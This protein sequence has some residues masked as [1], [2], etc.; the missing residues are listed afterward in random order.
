MIRR[1]MILWII[2]FRFGMDCIVLDWGYVWFS[3]VIMFSL[4]FYTK[5]SIHILTWKIIIG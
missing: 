5:I 1:N 4:N 3:M 2:G